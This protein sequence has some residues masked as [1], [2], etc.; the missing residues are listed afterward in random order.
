VAVLAIRRNDRIVR[1]QRLHG[2]DGHRLLSD[3]K[4]KEAADLSGAVQ[5]GA[6]LLE[7]PDAQHL[8]EERHRVM[9]IQRRRCR[10]WLMGQGNGRLTQTKLKLGP[11]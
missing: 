4:M 5:L 2:A 3:T 9:A 6:F 7:T 10:G 8:G 11:T 1:R